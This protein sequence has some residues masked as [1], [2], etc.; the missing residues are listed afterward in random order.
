MGIFT[1][2]SKKF[3]DEEKAEIL[4]D[5]DIND[6]INNI[7]KLIKEID[8]KNFNVIANSIQNPGNDKIMIALNKILGDI[9]QNINSSSDLRDELVAVLYLLGDK[10]QKE[11]TESLIHSIRQKEES[12]PESKSDIETKKFWDFSK[13]EISPDSPLKDKVKFYAQ[14]YGIPAGVLTAAV[15]GLGAGAAKYLASRKS[16]KRSPAKASPRKTTRSKRS[17]RSSRMTY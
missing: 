17:P 8:D 2:T 6:A 15:G 7:K 16:P 4:G 11:K 3:T 5:I 12:K 1:S 14:K 9:I 10:S 13:G